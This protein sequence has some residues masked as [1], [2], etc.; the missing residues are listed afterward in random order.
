[1]RGVI[2]LLSRETRAAGG[3]PSRCG[4]AARIAFVQ[5]DLEPVRAQITI[6]ETSAAGES[7]SGGPPLELCYGSLS[8]GTG[9]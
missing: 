6:E 7:A 2:R 3:T 4:G 5:V 8:D 1:M 9:E